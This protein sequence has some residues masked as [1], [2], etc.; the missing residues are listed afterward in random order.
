[1]LEG[2]RRMVGESLLDEDMAVETIHLPPFFA[3]VDS[4]AHYFLYS[5][6]MVGGKSGA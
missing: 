6:T 1:M 2:N 4:H 5:M 3:Q